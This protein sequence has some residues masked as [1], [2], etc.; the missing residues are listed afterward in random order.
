MIALLTLCSE[1]FTLNTRAESFAR[2][3]TLPNGL[4]LIVSERNQ[5]PTIHLQVL[6][7]AG[8][9]MD[10]PLL[11]GLA[12]L[13]A[14][15]LPQGTD[16]RDATQI[17]RQVE[18]V[19][20]ALSAS[21]ESDYATIRLSILKKDLPLGLSIL[22]DILLNPRF[23]QKEIDRKIS[24]LKARLK[25]MEEDP[26]QVAQKAFAQKLFGPH[27]YA[28]PP[29]GSLST[30]S[31][32]TREDIVSFFQDYYRPN[33]ASILI[34][35][36]TSLEESG[37]MIQE[38]LKGWKPAPIH[39]PPPVQ[40]PALTGPVIEKID[41]PISQASIVWGHLGI[42][43]SNPDFY[44]LQVMNY[45]LGGGGFVS[46]L[47]D[48]IRDNLGLTYGISSHFDA[49]EN[50]GSF[51]IAMETKSQNTNQALSEISKEI[52]LFLEKGI[53]PAEL[54]EAKAYLTGSFPLRMDTNA[55]LVRLLTA[56]EF[57]GLG[58]DF[59]ERYPRLINQVTADE[60][61]RVARAYLKPENFLLVVVGN[62]KDIQLK[63]SW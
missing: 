25:R 24:E 10:P 55:K 28:H 32:I 2:K 54:S 13:V 35:G 3:T 41:R 52:H 36:Q 5:L 57:Y 61:Q 53:S 20:G 49:R 60:V 51:Q 12:N 21:A 47:V 15:L 11:P 26:R 17:S 56:V 7:R 62:Q 29:E 46:R 48:I 33:N 19:G 8:S 58:L 4:T 14:E 31:S 9:A 59:P 18:S 1:A 44:A 34:V 45:I 37:R 6:I 22:S 50:T 40:P 38:V 30:L 43:R 63:E 39:R 42:A 27:P 16:Q 23:E